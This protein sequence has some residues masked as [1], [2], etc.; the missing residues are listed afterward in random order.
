MNH[1][2]Y[3]LIALMS[4]IVLFFTGCFDLDKIPQGE[5]SSANALSSNSEM[6]KYLNQFYESG[7]KTQSGALANA[8]GI[9]YGD[10]RS[11]NM[12]N[13]SPNVRLSG[14]MTLS[15]AST[16]SQ[17]NK[18]RNI[19]FFLT[20]A[21]NNK[22]EGVDKNHFI[23][24]AYYFRAW[25]YFDLVKNYGDVAWVDK[26]LSMDEVNHPRESR[27]VIT[28]HI[29]DDLDVA[30]A[31]LKEAKNSASMRVHRDVAR[32]LKAE[33]ALFEA[34][35][36]K[37]HKAENDL[38]YSKEVTDAKINHYL[39]QARDAAKAVIDR[40][41]WG[42]YSEGENPY[43]HLFITLDLS[44]NKEVLWWKKYNAADNIGHS[45]TRYINEGGGQT[46]ISKS[47]VDDYLTIDGRIFRGEELTE[48]EKI[49]GRELSPAIRDPRLSQTV[50]LPGT[51]MKP[52]GSVYV[53]PPLQVTTYHQNTTGYSMLKFNEYNT[54]YLATVT[55]EYKSQAPAIQYRYAEVL[56]TY[57]EALA[58]LD[59]A[60]NSE[61][62]K[63][64]LKPL[65][66][67]V[68]MPGVDFDREYNFD[69]AYPFRNLNKYI[70][71]VRRERRIELACEGFR[72]DDILRWAAAD[73][74]IN[75]QRPSGARFVGSTLQA[76]NNP[77]GYYNGT[78]KVG[79]NIFINE[80]GYIDPYQKI[81]TQGFGFRSDRDYLL[82]I[83]ERMLTLTNNL[84]KQNP[85]W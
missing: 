5:F 84:W 25:F 21:K 20:N 54:P 43:Q 53:F 81:M 9:A 51:Q 48:A 49:Y 26:V 46:G 7:V 79:T 41:V 29:L 68:G 75:G 66:D 28:D 64:A 27:L 60:A 57:A 24:E 14:L 77:G 8:S 32:A 61:L 52:D 45:V 80:E 3:I 65:R 74:L 39:E 50:C 67:R 85:G 23:G 69:P 72:F 18:I 56:L 58:E 10:Q 40:G 76:E 62:I 82:P 63:G 30:I 15:N 34:T 22:E 11:D 35:W 83:Q 17:Y 42:I 2:Q 36:Q 47:L 33:V 16:L 19:N 6:E 4:G 44:S 31:L 55:G 37:Y 38:F 13:A 73:E 12:V 70:Q 78:L 1:L 71:V 59:G